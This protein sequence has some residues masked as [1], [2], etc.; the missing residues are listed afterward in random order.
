[1]EDKKKNEEYLEY[2]ENMEYDEEEY[3]IIE[4]DEEDFEELEDG[5]YEEY[6]EYEEVEEEEYEEIEEDDDMEKRLNLRHEP[7]IYPDELTSLE[8]EYLY[9]GMLFNNPKAISRFF[10]E[11]GFMWV[12]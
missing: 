2:D 9:V 11:Y 4:V 12:C 3:E 5:E 7:S 8:L 6:E 1:M 10:F